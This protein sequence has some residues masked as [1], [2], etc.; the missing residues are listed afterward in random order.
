MGRCRIL[1]KGQ[2]AAAFSS[3]EAAARSRDSSL[4]QQTAV[5]TRACCL[6]FNHTEGML[7]CLAMTLSRGLIHW[8]NVLVNG[9]DVNHRVFGLH[10]PWSCSI[11]RYQVHIRDIVRFTHCV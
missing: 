9:V 4:L 6:R 2:D 5:G 8:R 3:E 7:Y 11:I 1:G 10:S